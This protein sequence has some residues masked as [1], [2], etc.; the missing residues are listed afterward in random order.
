MPQRRALAAVASAALITCAAA[1]SIHDSCDDWTYCDSNTCYSCDYVCRHGCDAYD[2]DCSVCDCSRCAETTSGSYCGGACPTGEYG[3]DGGDDCRACGAGSF[4]TDS[5]GDSDGVG[6]SR[7]ATHCNPCPAGSYSSVARSWYC[8]GCAE[9]RFSGVAG[10]SRAEGC[11]PC[12]PG[13]FTASSAGD[14][15]GVGERTGA[16]HCNACPAGRFRSSSDPSWSC[17]QCGSGTYSTGSATACLQCPSGKYSALSHCEDCCASGHYRPVG[18]VGPAGC[19]QCDAPNVLMDASLTPVACGA[20][21]CRPCGPGTEYSGGTCV[22]CPPGRFRGAD[23][24][25]PTASCAICPAGH[26]TLRWLASESATQYD[27]THGDNVFAADDLSCSDEHGCSSWN[28]PYTDN[29]A[30]SE[31]VGLDCALDSEGLSH[32]ATASISFDGQARSV[33]MRIA[34]GGSRGVLELN[35]DGGGWDAVCK[36]C[37][38]SRLVR[39]R[40]ANLRSS[41]FRR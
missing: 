38:L 10:S 9:G 27:A 12:Q 30:D 35:I 14:M 2:G 17:E 18:V 16:S 31:T 13:H 15:D 41:H 20:T 8:E 34:G 24:T 22:T 29:C 6:V 28:A 40:V 5:S 32:T 36:L 23:V 39:T 21:Q 26:F 7:D 3:S 37:L 19:I 4:A 33:Q 1:C 25:D 11:G